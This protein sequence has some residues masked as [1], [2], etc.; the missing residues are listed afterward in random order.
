MKAL[1]IFKQK[2]LPAETK[3]KEIPPDEQAIL[4]CIARTKKFLMSQACQV[5]VFDQC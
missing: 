4:D 2:D 5:K 3:L 1:T